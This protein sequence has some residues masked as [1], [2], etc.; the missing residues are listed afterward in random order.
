MIRLGLLLICLLLRP[1]H[2]ET[3]APGQL[4]RARLTAVYTEALG[5]VAPRTLEPVPLSDLVFWGLQGVSAADPS[6]RVVV[7]EGVVRLFQ[8][9]RPVFEA[10]VPATD[11]AS[12]WA[13]TAAQVTEAA[14]AASSVLRQAGTQGIINNFFAQMLGRLD[15]YSR[16]V[17]PAEAGED[18]ESR[19]GHAGLGL[20]V[21][22]LKDSIEV[23]AVVRDSPAAMAGLRAGDTLVS[24]DGQHLTR[25]DDKAIAALLAGPD[26]THVTLVW[27]ARD[28]RLHQVR[29]TRVMVPP[30]TVHAQRLGNA[31]LLRVTSFSGSTAAHIAQSVQ[32]ALA[33]PHPVEGIVLDLRDDRGGLLRQAVTATDT[34]LPAGVIATSIGRDPEARNIWRSAEGELAE[35]MPLVILVDGLTA[36]AAEVVAAALADRGRGVV[37]G[38]V[39]VGKGLVQTIDPLPD[40]GELFVSWSQLIAPR[41]WPLQGVG[42]MPQ[43]CTSLGKE[44]LNRQLKALAEGTQP[45]QDALQRA[46]SARLPVLADQVLAIRAPCPA[47][48]GSVLDLEAARVLIGNP[49]IYASALLPPMTAP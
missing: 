28:H 22:L 3:A 31:L 46:R 7:R 47:A 19:A 39:T 25:L 11:A 23:T 41:G 34:F 13:M 20:A 32:E 14:F 27:R 38:S 26:G 30:E 1:L 44:A 6:L 40:G 24:V 9:A 37:V 33:P 35:N 15:P 12:D 48:S 45:M 43:L 8:D 17:P 29:M 42:V 16:Y 36:S 49:A 18:R 4:D 5:F 2:A 10:P 21:R